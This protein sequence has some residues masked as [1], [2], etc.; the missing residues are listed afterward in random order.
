MATSFLYAAGT[1]GYVGGLVNFLTTDLNT[2]ASAAVILSS[3]N[4]TSGVFSQTTTGNA[5]WA[6]VLYVNGTATTTPTGAPNISGWFVKSNDGGTTFEPATAA[7]PRPA[8]FIIQLPTAALVAGQIFFA[9]GRILLPA[10]S[11]KVLV[12][13]NSN[14]ALT[15]TGNKIVFGAIGVQSV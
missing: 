1:S 5:I 14:V 8:D 2:W 7:L 15:G 13:N 4:G 6:D 11:F 12:Q 9:A 10:S 3:V